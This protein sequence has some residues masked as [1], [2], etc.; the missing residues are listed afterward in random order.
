MA[1]IQYQ[2]KLL[3][4]DGTARTWEMLDKRGHE[5]KPGDRLTLPDSDKATLELGAVAPT[6]LWQVMRRES[7]EPP[8]TATLICRR[9]SSS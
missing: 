7:A 8:F 6:A 2:L 1:Q 4:K 9:L 3:Q 5:Y